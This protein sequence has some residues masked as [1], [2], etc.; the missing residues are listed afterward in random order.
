MTR[1]WLAFCL[2]FAAGCSDD[3]APEQRRGWSTAFD[4][5]DS[6][7]LLS[8]WGPAPNDVYAVGG[9]ESEGAIQHFDGSSW[10]ALS[11]GVSVPLLNWVTGFAANDITVVGNEGTVVHWDGATWSAQTTPTGEPLWGVWGAAPT[12]LWAVGG[13]GR[14]TG[15]ATLL[16]FDGTSWESVALPPLQKAGVNALFK[17]WGTS[18]S[19]V[20]AVGQKGAVI[21]YDGSAWSEQL[22]GASDD[23]IALWGTGPDFVVAVGG[24]SIGI[25]SVWN[26][27]EWKTESLAPVPGLNGVWMRTQDAVHVVGAAGTL[28]VLRPKDFSFKD[29]SR[30]TELDIHG[31][32][33]TAAGSLFAVGGNF[34]GPVPPYEGIALT[35]KL[36]DDE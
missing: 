18:A 22:V 5:K 10:Q 19:N 16:H 30:D 29:E 7:W 17:V 23:L 1:Y 24:R 6:G 15:V 11:L 14:A 25:A 12:D 13:S 21:H 2:L 31:V 34:L 28:G 20:W 36:L 32:F 8:S 26:G 33:G 4:A 9:T 35:R 3:P 27:S